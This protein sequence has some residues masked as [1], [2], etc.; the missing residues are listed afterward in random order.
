MIK[1][2]KEKLFLAVRP[3][4]TCTQLRQPSGLLR[5]TVV[6]KWP[7]TT[8]PVWEN[9]GRIRACGSVERGEQPVLST[10]TFQHWFICPRYR[11]QLTQYSRKRTRRDVGNDGTNSDGGHDEQERCSQPCSC[12]HIAIHQEELMGRNQLR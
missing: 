6:I 11:P 3:Y 12:F 5:C 7:S 9:V 8:R 4:Y 10:I 2:P 1:R